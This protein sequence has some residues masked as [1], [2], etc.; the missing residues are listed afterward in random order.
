MPAPT[1]HWL[2]CVYVGSTR[3]WAESRRESAALSG[4][5]AELVSG[6]AGV[7]CP[8]PGAAGSRGD[9]GL[10]SWRR[11]GSSVA[12]TMLDFFTIFSK[13]GLVLWCFQGVS[14]SCTGPVNALIRSVLL[15][16][17]S[18]RGQ[19][20]ALFPPIRSRASLDRSCASHPPRP[21]PQAGRW[22]VA[23]TPLLS[24][25]AVRPPGNFAPPLPPPLSATLARFHLLRL[26]IVP[27]IRPWQLDFLLFRSLG[28]VVNGKMTSQNVNSVQL[29]VDLIVYMTTTSP[30]VPTCLAHPV[31]SAP[32]NLVFPSL[33]SGMLESN[34]PTYSCPG[35][36]EFRRMFGFFPKLI[37]EGPKYGFSGD[38][39][40]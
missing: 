37:V 21:P 32:T 34:T 25:V 13:G 36:F 33:P 20:S 2:A 5:A 17:P 38:S 9:R 4:S 15:Q 24:S 31:I 18:P 8:A 23:G 40:N 19:N 3:P 7:T 35:T 27:S 16:V 39:L 29:L 26:P 1:H 14:D 10:S 30:L 28:K 11:P 12:A 6:T 22:V